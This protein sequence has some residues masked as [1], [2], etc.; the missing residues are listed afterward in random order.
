DYGRETHTAAITTRAQFRKQASEN[1]EDIV[2]DEEKAEIS[3]SEEITDSSFQPISDSELEEV[4]SATAYS[5]PEETE[6]PRPLS[7]KQLWHLRLAHASTSVISKIPSIKS[8][9]DSSKCVSCIRAKHHRRPFHKSN[10][11]AAKK[12]QYIHS[13]LSGPHIQSLE[14]MKWFIT[15]M[16][17]LTQCKWVYMLPSKG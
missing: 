9:Y 11:Q 5:S 16:C 10:F 15:F 14:K 1:D 2:D 8:T 7:P 12:V 13:D 4:I 3:D 17:N 6:E